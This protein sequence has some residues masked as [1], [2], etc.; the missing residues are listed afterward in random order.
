MDDKTAAYVSFS[1]FLGIGPIK[2]QSIKKT[3]R[4]LEKAYSANLTDLTKAVGINIARQFIEFRKDLNIN[5]LSKKFKNKNIKVIHQEN[6]L[7]PKKLLEISDPPICLY[8]KGN[9]EKYEFDDK[10]VSVVGT[11][12]PTSY[13][14]KITQD[15]VYSLVGSGYRIV[16][17]LALGIDSIAHKSALESGGKTIAFLGCGVDIIYPYSNANLYN[18]ILKK[19]GLIIS[20]FPPGMNVLKG[21]FIARNR[22]ISG[23]SRGVIVVEGSDRSGSLITAKY[24]AEQGKDVYAI[25][26]N[27]TSKMSQAPNILIKE[28]AKPI[29]SLQDIAEEFNLRKK[30]TF[31]KSDYKNLSKLE[32]T[33][34]KVLEN[35]PRSID[36]ILE[37]TQNEISK[38]LQSLTNLELKGYVLKN[39]DGKYETR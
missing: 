19:D 1:H 35:E 23:I 3:F 2:F 15:I 26:G 17:G 12:M 21:L 28:G 27:I 14:Q 25:P 18:S 7:F 34:I 38:V 32:M 8:V 4:S 37:L 16:S 39:M 11:R 31:K 5:E 30:V 9:I 29:I 24:A 6:K 36:E 13:G 33:L 20:E 22:L 10:H